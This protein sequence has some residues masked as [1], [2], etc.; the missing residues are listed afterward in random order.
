MKQCPICQ[1]LAFDDA[2]TCYGCLHDFAGDEPESPSIPAQTTAFE[3]ASAEASVSDQVAVAPDGI[4]PSFVI[5]IR[6]ERERSGFT[7]WTCTVDLV[8]VR[9]T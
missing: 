2:A 1:S 7:S 4:P 3:S 5:K 8:P 9:A 6:P